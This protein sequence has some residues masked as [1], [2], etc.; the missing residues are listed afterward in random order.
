MNH[1]DTE[2]TRTLAACAHCVSSSPGSAPRE[3]MVVS[4]AL[5]DEP[6]AAQ[7]GVGEREDEPPVR[8]SE[9]AGCDGQEI[10]VIGDV[11]GVLDD[12]IDDY[13]FAEGHA[14]ELGGDLR[15]AEAAGCDTLAGE[16]G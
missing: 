1:T 15:R 11:Q 12:D 10:I 4:Q 7:V 5:V 16:P 9:P 8:I 3:R 6:R 2:S 13:V 14:L